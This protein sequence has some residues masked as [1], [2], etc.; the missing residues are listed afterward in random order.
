MISARRSAA[1]KIK[2]QKCNEK[3]I[4]CFVV[5]EKKRCI[6]NVPAIPT[7]EVI[8]KNGHCPAL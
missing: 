5:M 8:N 7:Q 6:D 3:T 4:H 2:V 1:I